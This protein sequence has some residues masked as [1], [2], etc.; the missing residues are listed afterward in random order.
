MKTKAT[1]F[2]ISVGSIILLLI[3][4]LVYYH[5]GNFFGADLMSDKTPDEQ[6]VIMR[7][8]YKEGKT[9]QILKSFVS[10]K[11]KY[12]IAAYESMIENAPKATEILKVHFI[13]INDPDILSRSG[14]N[15]FK[16]KL[17]LAFEY[18]DKMDN[19]LG[20]AFILDE[21]S[22]PFLINKELADLKQNYI[23]N[24]ASL[25]HLPSK[26]NTEYIMISLVSLK[27]HLGK[28]K[29]KDKF[30]ISP[31]KVEFELTEEYDPITIINNGQ[32]TFFTNIRSILGKISDLSEY[33]MNSLCPQQCP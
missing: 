17:Y 26:K 29:E 4:Y 10:K 31:Q 21:N 8:N 28:I 16:G 18:V 14:L 30:I 33:N 13:Q 6:V 23:T 3:S 9:K 15:N 25:I 19:K 27:N 12:D 5:Y 11:F 20:N 1:F 24:I 7:G 2:R 32:L 22:N